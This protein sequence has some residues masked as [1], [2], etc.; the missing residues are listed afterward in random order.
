MSKESEKNEIQLL[1]ALVVL[2]K[3]KMLV[4]KIVV[5]ITL[6]ALVVSLIWPKTYKSTATV[7]P[8]AQQRSMPGIAGALGGL[9]PISLGT[10]QQINPEVI[11]TI[12]NS[13]T[14]RVEMIEAFDLYEVYGSSITEELL[15]SLQENIRIEERREG[16]FGFNPITSLAIS[17]TDREPERAQQM[18]AFLVK[19]LDETVN[20]IN[21]KNALEQFGVVR[22]RY[23]RNVEEMEVAENALK[24]FQET[25][26]IIE[27]EEQARAVIETLAEIKARRIE[28]EMMINVMRQSVSEDNADLR[29]LRRTLA[30][31]DRQYDEYVRKSDQE[32]RAARVLPPLL[33]VPDL[34]LHYYRLLRDVTVQNKIYE[35]L[36][37]QYDFQQV[38]LEAEKRGIQIVD[39]AHLPTYKESPKRAFIVL[40][41]M[42]FSIFLSML[43]VF[44]RHTVETGKR[45]NSD[46]YR[47]IVELQQNLLFRR[48]KKADNEE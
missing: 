29:R 2:A 37:P 19:R 24:E 22:D 10:E 21:R 35:T 43:V 16:G 48:K 38:M 44:Y 9:L 20:E 4:I 25:Y 5:S 8:P 15:I 45:T 28:T 40:G 1:D 47:K 23:Q 12:L 6:I 41:G 14:L 17:V 42:V 39:E 31:L 32:A 34:A 11:L 46:Q 7:L 27:V 33:D 36:Y 18:A 3:H 26:G 13:R 30:E